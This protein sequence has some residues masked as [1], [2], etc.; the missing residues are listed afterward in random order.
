MRP[1]NWIGNRSELDVSLQ[2]RLGHRS[3]PEWGLPTRAGNRSRGLSGAANP[4]GNRSG[5]GTGGSTTSGSRGRSRALGGTS[6]SSKLGRGSRV[7]SSKERS[8]RVEF[9]PRFREPCSS[10]LVPEWTFKTADQCE[11]RSILLIRSGL[12]RTAAVD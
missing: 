3:E 11:P 4:A 8:A 10:R 2:H 12:E 7:N 1:P 5:T 9:N 6:G